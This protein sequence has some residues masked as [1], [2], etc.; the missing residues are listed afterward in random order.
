VKQD[1]SKDPFFGRLAAD[2]RLGSGR[3]GATM[4]FYFPWIAIP[5]QACEFLSGCRA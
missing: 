3:S 2:R 5:R 4:R 1:W